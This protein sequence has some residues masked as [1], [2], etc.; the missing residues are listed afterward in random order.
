M[1]EVCNEL[2]EW[3]KINQSLSVKYRDAYPADDPGHYANDGYNTAMLALIDKLT[4]L[5][6]EKCDCSAG[7]K[8]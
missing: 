3:A 6:K 4:K 8:V 1:C 5:E 2:R 7:E